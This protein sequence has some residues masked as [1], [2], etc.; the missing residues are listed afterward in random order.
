MNSVIFLHKET[1]QK[2]EIS[3][4]EI[5][6]Q[7]AFQHKET[8]D[9]LHQKKD[10]YDIYCSCNSKAKMHTR[11]NKAK[12]KVYIA[13]NSGLVKEHLKSCIS[14]NELK[15]HQLQGVYYPAL[16][17]KSSDH[18][19]LA[20]NHLGIIPTQSTDDLKTASNGNKGGYRHANMTMG[21]FG[22]ELLSRA[23]EH[24]MDNYFTNNE[25][26]QN[27]KKYKY[28]SIFVL[29]HAL[30]SL[31][32]GNPKPLLKVEIKKGVFLEDKLI[33]GYQ[34]TGRIFY[35]NKRGVNPVILMPFIKEDLAENHDENSHLLRLQDNKN[36]REF[37]I[38]K[39][40]WAEM[41]LTDNTRVNYSNHEQYFI[42]GLGKF[43]AYGEPPTL[44]NA[45]LIPTTKR[46]M[47]VDSSYEH[48]FFTLLEEQK[49]NYIKPNQ[50][51]EEL[52]FLKPDAILRDTSIPFIIEVFGMST[53]N[54]EYHQARDKKINYYQA[55]NNYGF[56][57]WD[58][59][60]L[61][62]PGKLPPRKK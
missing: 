60:T 57:K 38:D 8:L 26:V 1:G 23:W 2:Q 37:L 55:L 61:E 32:V 46:G 31:F 34:K 4:V 53:S 30:R 11:Y 33:L 28:P 13:T 5:R 44:F 10:Q 54:L 20:V 17:I 40:E 21:S 15:E 45:A 48:I 14:F 9:M 56:Y 58:A 43:N 36:I 7:Q 59:Y 62:Q 3:Y 19:K 49:R 6:S 42:I 29:R 16:E 25:F 24:A 39:N 47:F 27:Q 12:Q 51:L 35:E 22:R 18:I 50:L 52:D 41:T